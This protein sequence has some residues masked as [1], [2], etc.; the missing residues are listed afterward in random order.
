MN[1]RNVDIVARHFL[2]TVEAMAD[3]GLDRLE[4]LHR[5]F[6]RNSKWSRYQRVAI[7]HSSYWRLI[8]AAIRRASI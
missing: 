2:R 3:R 4:I 6:G 5:L 1:Q 7:A 8:W